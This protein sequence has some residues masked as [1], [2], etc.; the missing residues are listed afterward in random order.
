MKFRKMHGLGDDFSVVDSHRCRADLKGMHNGLFLSM[1]QA[2][3]L[4]GPSVKSA[5]RARSAIGFGQAI[6]KSG[7]GPHDEKTI[8]GKI[9]MRGTDAN[10]T[11]VIEPR[12]CFSIASN[13]VLKIEDMLDTDGTFWVDIVRSLESQWRC[14]MKSP[15]RAHIPRQSGKTLFAGHALGQA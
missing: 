11:P 12:A 5:E 4:T 3:R 9:V 10:F 1:C 6:F 7:A 15:A 8:I 14:G 2:V 13:R